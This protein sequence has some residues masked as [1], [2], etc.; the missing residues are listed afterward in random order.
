MSFSLR[1][2]FGLRQL[3]LL[4]A[5]ALLVLFGVEATKIIPKDPLRP[6]K[7]AAA[8]HMKRAMAALRQE[9]LRQ[10]MLIDSQK[11]PN[12]TGIIGKDYT[13]LTTTLGSLS[14]KR[15]STNPNF[16]GLLV[17]MLRQAGAQKGDGA[18]ISFSGSFP[19]LNIA[20]LAA[21]HV[22]QLEPVIISSVGASTYGANEPRWTWLDME[23]T[24]REKG[25]FPYRSQAASL[26]GLAKT[27][28]GLGGQGIEMAREAIIRNKIPYLDEQGEETFP[29]DLA[30][31]L[32][33]YERNLGSK[34]LSVFINVGGPLTSLGNC[35]EAHMLPVGLL[36]HVPPSHHPRRGII[37]K[38]RE[39]GVPV[40]HLL[41]IKKI[42]AQYGLA[43]DPIP[44]PPIPS[45]RVMQP[46]TYIRS[47]TLSGM[48]L[49]V[50]FALWLRESRFLI[51]F[52]NS[53][54]Q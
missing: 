6:Y 47:F 42:A 51:R 29:E 50:L 28:G 43:I 27:R 31:R 40:I 16:A 26:G 1:G 48:I 17:E 20:T 21:I 18:A 33:L 25:I 34:R 36:Q 10:G 49:L 22:L 53:R 23:S 45:G 3:W 8:H 12:E 9:R 52:G 35:P 39:K 11:D 19:A 24:L 13:D 7:V 30:R 15:T 32:A 38:M 4:A 46:P 2:K 5:G 37:F 14:S 44:L 54:R 41:N